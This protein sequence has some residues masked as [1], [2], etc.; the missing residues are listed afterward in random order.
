VVQKDSLAEAERYLDYY[1]NQHG[2]EAALDNVTAEIGVQSGMFA[3][4]EDAERFRFHFKAGFAGMPL[5]GTAQMIAEQCNAY[6]ELG[7]DGLCLTWLDYHQGLDDFVDAV[8]PR[9]EQQGLRQP[10]SPALE[11]V[12]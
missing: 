5:V 3:N 7:I 8:L 9:L 12:A 10:Y 4:A 1:V 11:D 2:D 6:N